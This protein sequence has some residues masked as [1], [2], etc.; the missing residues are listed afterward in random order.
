MTR[1]APL[2]APAQFAAWIRGHWANEA[3]HH[4]RDVI[5]GEGVLPAAIT[6][7][8]PP[9][10]WPPLGSP[11]HNQYPRLQPWMLP[12]WTRTMVGSGRSGSHLLL[13][14]SG[15]HRDTCV[16]AGGRADSART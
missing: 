14:P 6:P 3:L 5:Y 10:S 13:G 7:G 1:F 15:L 4:S 12:G 8:T 16:L 9:G 2:L 11:R